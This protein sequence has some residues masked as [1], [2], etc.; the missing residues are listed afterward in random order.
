MK[1]SHDMRFRDSQSREK[2]WYSATHFLWQQE[3]PSYQL[4][5]SLLVRHLQ[6]RCMCRSWRSSFKRPLAWLTQ[7]VGCQGC[8]NNVV[9]SI[10]FT[11]LNV[12]H[13][14]WRKNCCAT[15]KSMHHLESPSIINCKVS[16]NHFMLPTFSNQFHSFSARLHSF[17]AQF[18]STSVDVYPFSS[19]MNWE[20]FSSFAK[21]I[22]WRL[23]SKWAVS[24]W[25]NTVPSPTAL[26]RSQF[27]FV[28]ISVSVHS[29]VLAIIQWFDYP[30]V[31]ERLGAMVVSDWKDKELE[32]EFP[33]PTTSV[34]TRKS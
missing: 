29:Q 1:V 32:S 8:Q 23:P 6:L 31:W 14:I 16:G 12:P 28:L 22:V 2:L 25:P 19:S 11:L 5:A 15:L 27:V 26:R 33:N 4:W 10:Y 17:S 7:L 30:L 24:L 13:D 21:L 9:I 20:L 3:T 34:Q 18:H